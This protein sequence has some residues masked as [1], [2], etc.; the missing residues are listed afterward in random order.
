MKDSDI[1][2][3]YKE[4][5]ELQGRT[6]KTVENYGSA[7]RIYIDWL[8]DKNLTI[9][10][11]N[12]MDNKDIIE[13]F[14]KYL[15]KERVKENGNNISFARI[16]VIFS[17]LNNL[18]EYLEYNQYVKKNIVL[19]VRKRY[20]KRYKK[21]YEPAVRKVI[22]VEEMS[23]YLNSIPN[24]R[25]RAINVL[26]VKTGVR[27]E[28]MRMIDCNDID[29]D[30]MKITIK[31][32]ESKKRTFPYVFFDDECKRVLKYWE[33]RREMLAP[34]DKEAFF[35]GDYGRRISKNALYDSV[36]KWSTRFGLHT[37]T[38]DRLEDHF[39]FH[40]MRHCFTTYLRRNGMAREYRKELRGD[41]R[42]DVMDLYDH[43]DEKELK[44]EY[45]AAIPKFNV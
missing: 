44:R 8:H 2:D 38:S 42:S 11:I 27:R 7:V 32:R 26:A 45:L 10:S 25:D 36:V 15:R 17:A 20:L 1:L 41:K 24:P 4:D 21:G 22:D 40:N 14:L 39:S 31:S 19:V 3:N 6:P 5:L 43:F 35:I 18:Y 34:L 30:E 29:W 16:K 9:L 23:K 13:D 37:P 28:N 33:K 12:D